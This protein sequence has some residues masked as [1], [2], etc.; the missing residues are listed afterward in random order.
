MT[1]DPLPELG[2]GL[3]DPL[4]ALLLVLHLTVLQEKRGIFSREI[5]EPFRCRA[6]KDPHTRMKGGELYPS[7]LS[8]IQGFLLRCRDC[9]LYN[10]VTP[11][12]VQRMIPVLSRRKVRA[13]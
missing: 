12:G 6:C 1:L 9:G 3:T 5:P 8:P 7:G 4:A 11:T 13:A 10:L 2:A